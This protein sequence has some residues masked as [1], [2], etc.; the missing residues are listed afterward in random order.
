[1]KK[2][3]HDITGHGAGQALRSALRG[4]AVCSAALCLTAACSR[5][6]A[7][8]EP[9][10]AGMYDGPLTI[11]ADIEGM[12]ETRATHEGYLN[13]DE[14]WVLSTLWKDLFY[15]ND[16][17]SLVSY[18]IEY[19]EASFP[20]RY[21]VFMDRNDSIVEI[22]WSNMNTFYDYYEI[23]L[24]NG[25]TGWDRNGYPVNKYWVNEKEHN[26]VNFVPYGNDV[27]EQYKAQVEPEGGTMAPNDLI[28][29]CYYELAN[30]SEKI[31]R[32]TIPLR[33]LMSRV[34]VEITA[35]VIPDLEKK[36]VRVWLTPLA[37]KC[38]GIERPFNLSVGDP[39]RSA[40]L[41]D[42]IVSKN[43]FSLR[44]GGDED[45]VFTEDLYLL[46][47]ADEGDFLLPVEDEKKKGTYR[48]HYLIM[49]PQTTHAD[50]AEDQNLRPTL[51]IKIGE[52]T[53]AGMLPK[54]ITVGDE[55]QMFRKFGGGQNIT[56]K[57]TIDNAP[58]SIDIE[59]TVRQWK[60]KGT[61]LLG[62]DRGGIR[63][64]EDF[65]NAVNAFNEYVKS[66]PTWEPGKTKPEPLERYGDF[67][68]TGEKF[69][70]QFFG[71][72]EED[73]E[74]PDDCKI[75]KTWEKNFEVKLN[76][77]TVYGVDGLKD[78]NDQ[79]SVLKE[80]MLLPD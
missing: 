80:K 30:V 72:F 79:S 63:T 49:P 12:L 73:R 26:Y 2:K 9:A 19:F 4:I 58:P 41:I 18:D 55:P 35:P 22:K 40:L 32:I 61:W 66:G 17:D 70:F 52:K 54:D 44:Y 50:A 60:D 7:L 74:I 28:A 69:V 77:H 11:L 45:K 34:H 27:L 14:K 25:P 48:T 23:G 68:S 51:Y 5:E 39:N 38:Y 3:T 42:S 10:A 1:M 24:D 76:G 64:A 37:G 16:K 47:S 36:K 15:L 57:V 67:D 13:G 8:S 71:D 65:E 46:G 43:G 56:L 6:D 62:T 29:G 53:Y 75:G 33:H 59:A 21:G 31:R 78:G 20:D